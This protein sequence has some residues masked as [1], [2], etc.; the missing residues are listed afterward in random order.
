MLKHTIQLMTC[1]A[2]ICTMLAAE[3][4]DVW[5]VPPDGQ[6]LRVQACCVAVGGELRVTFGAAS[7]KGV[8]LTVRCEDMPKLN[9][10]WGMGKLEQ[11]LDDA[12]LVMR[13]TGNHGWERRQIQRAYFIRPDI[14]F[15]V[16]G[17][18]E[19]AI[20]RWAELPPAS[21]HRFRLDFARTRDRVEVSMDGRYFS[22]FPVPPTEDVQLSVKSG[23][24][25]ESVTT[26]AASETGRY[27]PVDI[28][29]NSHQNDL[30][31]V[32][33][34]LEP[35]AQNVEGIPMDVS[36]PDAEADVGLSRW[37]RQKTGA[38]AFYDP[39]YRRTAW[40]GVPETIMFSVPRRFYNYAHVLCAVED[41]GDESPSMSVRLA[42]Y[43]QAWDGGGGTQAD[44]TVVI[45][46]DDPKGCTSLKKVGTVRASAEGKARDLALYLVEIPLKTGE[47]ADYL[48][49]VEMTGYDTPDFFYL[50]LTRE[51]RTRVTVNYAYYEEKPLGP[52]SGV[53]VLGLTLEKAPLE[54]LVGSEVTGNA[55]YAHE[56]PRL[57]IQVDNPTS[58]EV[59]LHMDSC[60]TDFFGVEQ[61]R[62]R[63]LELAPGRT[64]LPYPLT[65]LAPGWYRARFT[66]STRG[67]DLWEQP[68]TLSLLPPDTR[69]AGAESPYGIWWFGRSHYGEPQA[70]KVLPLLQK[71]GFRHVTA[72]AHNPKY[73][74]TPETFARYQVTP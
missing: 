27:V 41:G 61:N 5:Q 67:R 70:D 21:E 13:L 34:P 56:D 53:H 8:V 4:A 40:D 52:A 57:Q 17:D 26:L 19:K 72:K 2:A 14:H 64:E 32:G 55:L 58:S 1:G 11:K 33:M 54:I 38:S 25:A 66:F 49:R 10:H 12:A 6:V 50:E 7:R 60:L 18:L 36:P 63:E 39:Y 31:I 37:L 20:Q 43:R 62:R 16:K 44:T 35:G 48:R 15:Y 29:R 30:Q 65:D 71:M 73:G 23:A 42:R 74:H 22:S 69:K 59:R 9:H 28:S 24:E 68:L 51:L 3:Q 46:P 45:D 47:L